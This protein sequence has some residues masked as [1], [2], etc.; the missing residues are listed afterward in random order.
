MFKRV[1]LLRM[2]V[3]LPALI[4]IL[5]CS[6]IKTVA[7]ISPPLAKLGGYQAIEIP[8]FDTDMDDVPEGVLTALPKA[9]AEEIKARNLGF[10][11]V[12]YGESEADPGKSTIVMF[13]EV[14]DYV[15]P[16]DFS[17]EGGNITFGEVVVTVHLSVL[18]KKTG[19]EITNGD[20][21]GQNSLGLS[22]GMFKAIAKDIGDYMVANY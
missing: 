17:M 16:T 8:T 18:D 19:K 14:T 15:A 22:K 10:E 5:G 20:V 7:Y 6:N 2:A 3:L 11:Q 13:G 12:V 9:V 1:S 21:S 4:C